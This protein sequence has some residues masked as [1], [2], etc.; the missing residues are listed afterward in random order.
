MSGRVLTIKLT[1]LE[2]MYE[3]QTEVIV[4]PVIIRML[5]DSK[6]GSRKDEV[7]TQGDVL[8]MA[9]ARETLIAGFSGQS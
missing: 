5:W 2:N 8:T 7:Q 9:Q 1:G 6:H 3:V 4:R